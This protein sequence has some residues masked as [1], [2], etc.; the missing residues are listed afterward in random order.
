MTHVRRSIIG[1]PKVVL[2]NPARGLWSAGG[3]FLTM[4]AGHRLVSTAVVPSLA[5]GTIIGTGKPVDVENEHSNFME[6]TQ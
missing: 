6:S 1:T 5:T 2:A 4:N 3:A